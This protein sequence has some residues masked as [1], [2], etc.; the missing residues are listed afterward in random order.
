MTARERLV[1]NL[2]ARGIREERILEAFAQTPRE[3][4]VAEQWRD[5]AY[6]DKPLP[7][8]SGQTI[9]QPYMVAVMLQAL[10]LKG[11][12]NVLEV[13]AGSGY[14]AALLARLALQVTAMER[15]PE[16]AELA[17]V[18]LA[19]AGPYANVAVVCGDGLKGWPA[20][21]PFDAISVAAA[22]PTAPQAL[23]DQLAEGGR[24]VIPLG[25]SKEQELFVFRR[26]E[27]EFH[28]RSAGR[29]RFVPLV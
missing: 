2:R 23:L 15:I 7:I 14:H 28:R 17:R 27:G 20:R 13:G 10:E 9:S 22:G 26:E 3:L 29:C 6:E 21:A 4:F 18:N 11:D 12:E 1:E 5:Q 25:P 24:L 8:G 16:L 19:A